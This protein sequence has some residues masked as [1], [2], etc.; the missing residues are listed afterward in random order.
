M[1]LHKEVHFETEICEHLA[2]LIFAAVTGQIDV[3]GFNHRPN[4]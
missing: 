4:P 2:V 1:N 3:R